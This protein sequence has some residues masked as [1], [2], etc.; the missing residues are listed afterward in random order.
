VDAAK[1]TRRVALIRKGNREV[2][3]PEE[4]AELQT[5]QAELRDALGSWDDRLLGELDRM[6]AEAKDV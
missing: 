5:L 1:N 3:S 6:E 2:L 4:V